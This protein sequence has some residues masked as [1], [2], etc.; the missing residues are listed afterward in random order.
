M[1]YL[2]I[3][4]QQKMA[5]DER[6]NEFYEMAL[7]KVI[8]PDSVVLDLGAGLGTLGLIAAKLGAKKVYL[9]EPEDIIVV[10]E[11]IVARNGFSDRVFCIQGRIENIEI[12][13]KFDVIISVF[14]GNFLLQEDLLP[15]LFYARDKYLKEGGALLPQGGF[16]EAAPVCL[17]DF[18][19]QEIEVWSIPHKDIDP[20]PAR[21]YASHSIHFSHQSISSSS[22]LAKPEKLMALDFHTASTTHCD[23]EVPFVI[24]ESGTCHGLV[25]W[26][27]M[28]LQDSWLSTAPHEPPLHW[29]SAFLPLDPPIQVEAGENLILKLQRPPYGDWSWK[30]EYQGERQIHSTFFSTPRKLKNFKKIANDYRPQLD[31]KG[32]AALAV[33]SHSDGSKTIQEMSQDLMEQYPGLFETVEKARAFVLQLVGTFM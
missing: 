6:R 21:S 10:T 22:Y 7:S 8:T 27:Q 4:G 9:V 5:L 26:F 32:T 28:N 24:E 13:D 17:P 30:V 15:S 29:S 12:P 33:L 25:G 19:G 3:K 16:M 14:T 20:S 2:E 23:I 1:S 31:D 18:Y 11:E